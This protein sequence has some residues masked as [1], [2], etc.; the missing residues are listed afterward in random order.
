[1]LGEIP[2]MVV[3]GFFSAMGW[4]TASYTVDKF[5]PEKPKQETQI[6]TEWREEVDQ[7]G[8][9]TRTRKCEPKN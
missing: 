3:W 8:Q 9:T 4:M 1:M 6:C 5:V 2:Y 7:S